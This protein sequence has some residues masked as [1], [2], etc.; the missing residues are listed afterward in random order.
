MQVQ[1]ASDMHLLAE[2]GARVDWPALPD[3]IDDAPSIVRT[4]MAYESARSIGAD[5][6]A[7]AELLSQET[8]DLFEYGR[9]ISRSTYEHAIRAR[10]RLIEVFAEWI[11]PNDAIVTLAAAGEAPDAQTTGDPRFCSRWSLLGAP[12]ISIP[13]A[14]GPSGLPLAVQ[15]VGAP[16]LDR[17]L[18][19][20]ARWVEKRLTWSRVVRPI[21]IPIQ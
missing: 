12:A 9:S 5:A 2:H 7:R 19:G 3:G 16:G 21:S 14:L 20:I 1:F 13:T 17:H 4:V 10:L 6:L 8:V 11:R 15:I 18:L